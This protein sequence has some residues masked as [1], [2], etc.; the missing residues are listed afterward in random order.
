MH[1]VAGHAPLLDMP[2]PAIGPRVGQGQEEDR[3]QHGQ[4]AVEGLF[5]GQAAT[6]ALGRE[7]Q[8]HAQGADPDHAGRRDH[9]DQQ[10]GAQ[11]LLQA[12]EEAL[13]LACRRGS[14]HRSLIA[15]WTCARD[16]NDDL[17]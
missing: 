2:E 12:G 7:Q 14:G 4:N 9:E 3:H 6:H 13:P 16:L 11:R 5:E 17:D 15:H 1:E 8:G 10:D